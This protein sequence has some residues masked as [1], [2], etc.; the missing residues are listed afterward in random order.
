MKLHLKNPT[1]FIETLGVEKQRV[2]FVVARDGL[3][4]AMDFIAQT[5]KTYRRSLKIGHGGEVGY[6]RTFV[7]SCI[8][9]RRLM[10]YFET[11]QDYLS[12]GQQ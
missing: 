11:Y 2:K 12:K 5:H 4:R 3:I 8:D 9:F 1:Q 7:E 10:R 6:R